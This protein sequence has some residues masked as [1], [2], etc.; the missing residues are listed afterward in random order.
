ML[1]GYFT[2]LV[3]LI[4]EAVGAFYSVT[5]LAAIFSGAVI[6][7]IIMGGAL[8]VGKVTAAVWLKNNW[9]RAS[10]AY[11][12][13]L[14]PALVVLML[15]TSMGIF[16]FLSKAHSDQNLVSGDVQSKVAIYDEKI[17]TAR[18]NIEANRK[19]LSQMDAQVDQLLG[20]TT[21]DKGAERAVQIRRNQAKERAR[22]ASEIERDQ[23]LIAQLNEQAAPIRAEIRKVEADVGPIKYIAKLIYD[24]NPDANRLE[25]AVT[26][27]IIIIVAVFDPLAL[28]LILAAQQSLRWAR[29]ER[30]QSP[31]KDE[32]TVPGPVVAEEPAALEPPPEAEVVQE[33]EPEEHPLTEEEREKKELEEVE[34]FFWRGKMIAKA[35]D[36]EEDERRVREGNEAIAEIEPSETEVVL[37]EPEPE[38]PDPEYQR[39]L[40]ESA[41]VI[42]ELRKEIAEKDQQLEHLGG[43][44]SEVETLRNDLINKN[45]RLTAQLTEL[46]SDVERL[47]RE[48]TRLKEPVQATP[49][50]RLDLSTRLDDINLDLRAT[51]DVKP[52]GNAS[53]GTQFPDRP[54]KGDMF[55]RVDYLP[56]RLFKFN[57]TKWIESDK[58][59]TDQFAYEDSYIKHLID[60]LNTGEYDAD[61]LNDVEREKIKDYLERNANPGI[62]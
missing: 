25:K 61:D 8:E 36:A 19:A 29:E 5:G 16:G 46:L 11:K 56:S 6:P 32:P 23:K 33:P 24:D 4:I 31:A 18:D 52:T 28:V 30:E 37:P 42:E 47:K 2:L 3:A 21:D 15:L 39:L 51:D 62:Q 49:T 57:G 9:E 27:V 22:I 60:K 55:L 20:R 45:R 35:L 14:V 12:L 53:F 26:W 59:L 48:N 50:E 40:D 38:T 34:R 43:H 54:N 58:H 7:I 17:R 10:I 41:A 1:F 44:T 13:Y